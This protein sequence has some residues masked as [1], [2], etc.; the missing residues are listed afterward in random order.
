M[1]PGGSR[2]GN[3]DGAA[4]RLDLELGTRELGIGGL[5]ARLRRT[6]ILRHDGRG[7]DRGRGRMRPGGQGLLAQRAG[8]RAVPVGESAGRGYGQM[9]WLLAAQGVGAGD[10]LGKGPQM[11]LANLDDVVAFLAEAAGNGPVAAHR[12]VHDRHPDT[13]VLHIGDDLGQVFLRTD[14]KGIADRVVAGQ[15]GEIAADLALH[16]LPPPRPGPAQPQL[17]PGKIGE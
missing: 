15:G 4:R 7:V 3:G 17:Q 14:Q 10:Q 2:R 6:L 8:Y 5:G 11:P 16:A 12:D 13:E 9:V 1:D